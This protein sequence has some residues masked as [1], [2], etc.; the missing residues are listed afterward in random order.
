MTSAVSAA[1]DTART[2][3]A[4]LGDAVAVRT[5]IRVDAKAHSALA[6][7]RHDFRPFRGVR[8]DFNWALSDFNRALSD[9]S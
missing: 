9:S 8:P 3:A 2:V 6:L 5:V 1:D 4:M 7:E